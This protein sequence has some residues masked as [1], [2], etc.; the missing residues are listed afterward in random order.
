MAAKLQG[1]LALGPIRYARTCKA[2][3]GKGLLVL[4]CTNRRGQYKYCWKEKEKK[5]ISFFSFD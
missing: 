3:R 4:S 1:L 2:A 5:A